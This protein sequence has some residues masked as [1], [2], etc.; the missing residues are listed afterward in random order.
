MREY[1]SLEAFAD[2]LGLTVVD[3]VVTD[4]AT[5]A[6]MTS[7]EMRAASRAVESYLYSAVYR[8]DVDGYPVDVHLREAFADAAMEQARAIWSSEKARLRAEGASPLGR[9]LQSA[10]IGSVSYTVDG[11]ADTSEAGL[12]LSADVSLCQS[13]INVL[14]AARL[15]TRVWEYG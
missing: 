2:E 5:G 9:P 10:S 1:I 14:E 12:R 7:R 6:T 13:A 11:S 8:T 3:D 4:S 15:W